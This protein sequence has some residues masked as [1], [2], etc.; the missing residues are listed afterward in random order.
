MN[1]TEVDGMT[2]NGL[3]VTFMK[4]MRRSAAGRLVD[5]NLAADQTHADCGN[6]FVGGVRIHLICRIYCLYSS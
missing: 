6:S 3:R 1:D 2:G 4:P 5:F